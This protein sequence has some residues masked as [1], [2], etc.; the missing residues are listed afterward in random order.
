MYPK[1]LSTTVTM[2]IFFL[3]LKNESFPVSQ[4]SPIYSYRT[5]KDAN[6]RS[7][8]LYLKKCPDTQ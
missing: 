3:L 8:V 4:N 6:F 2:S 1:L 7:V 5:L